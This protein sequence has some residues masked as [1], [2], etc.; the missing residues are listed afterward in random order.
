MLE[1]DDPVDL[2]VLAGNY[3]QRHI[4]DRPY[5]SR[6]LQ[7][8]GVTQL[9]IERHEIDLGFP[10]HLERL[11]SGRHLQNGK[12]FRFEGAPKNPPQFGLVINDKNFFG[13]RHAFAPAF[14]PS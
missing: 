8:I 10:Q 14:S 6:K 1:S 13:A 11:L 5:L 12:P 4:L 7:P 3:H 9:Q 2:T